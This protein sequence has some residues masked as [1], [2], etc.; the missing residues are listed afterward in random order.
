MN[1]IEMLIIIFILILILIFI[2]Y[3][4]NNNDE[5]HHNN[6]WDKQPVMRKYVQNFNII[7]QIPKFEID[8]VD[9]MKIESNDN[10]NINNIGEIIKFLDDNFSGF[11]KIV[12]KNTI[13]YILDKKTTS[14]KLYKKNK[15]VGFIHS[16]PLIINYEGNEYKL[17]YVEYLCVSKELRGCNIASILIASIIEKMND[18][19]YDQNRLY[20]FKKDGDR[21]RFLPIIKSRY[22][23]LDI[24]EIKKGLHYDNHNN[25]RSINIDDIK[26]DEWDKKNIGHKLYIKMNEEEWKKYIINRNIYRI[27]IDNKKYNI[28][29]SIG[30]IKDDNKVFD[31]E[32]IYNTEEDS[33]VNK[34]NDLIIYLWDEGYKYITMNDI[35]DHMNILGCM[36]GWELGNNFQYYLYNGECRNI[37]NEDVN[38][39]IN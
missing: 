21:H 23:C 1:R 10:I 31:I 7:G 19:E 15:L 9:D 26:Y 37:E 33:Y 14:I 22:M 24:E 25:I 2:L 12:S 17:N 29:G 32:Y 18:I 6:F 13:E 3:Y 35:S 16:R 27:E 30:R 20:L 5:L 39:T 8:L 34:W 4:I 38:I 11:L 36:G 28:I